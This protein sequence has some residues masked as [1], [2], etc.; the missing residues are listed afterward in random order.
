MNIHENEPSF[1]VYSIEINKCSGS[2]NNIVDPYRKL[3]VPDI[4]KNINVKVFNLISRTN[5]K[6]NIEWHETQNIYEDQMQVFL[7]INNDVRTIN[8]NGKA[9]SLQRRAYVTNDFFW[10]LQYF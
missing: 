8:A 7:V 1:Y 10:K 5:E 4:V 6:R 2:C 3:C 9:E